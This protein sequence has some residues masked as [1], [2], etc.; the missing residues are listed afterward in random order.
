MSSLSH[1]SSI[2]EGFNFYD[3]GA[4]IGLYTRFAVQRFG[5]KKVIAFEPMKK[6]IKQLRRNV[7]LRGVNSDVRVI[8][9][10]VSDKNEKVKLQV[11]D[12]QSATASLNRVTGGEPAE[13][14]ANIGLDAKTETVEARELDYIFAENDLP[15]PDVLKIDVEGAEMMVLDGAREILS[16]HQ[17]HLIIETHGPDLA[18]QVLSFL[19]DEGYSTAARVEGNLQREN[20]QY[21]R[22]GPDDV[23]LIQWKYDARFIFASPDPDCLPSE[24]SP[25]SLP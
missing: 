12:V 25:Y 8:T 5:A 11:D 19:I 13:G 10:A 6:N 4:N 22:L 18:R 23:S 2:E 21:R 17:P 1:F 7:G 14:R 3:I 15:P 20:E 24:L 9:C 16:E